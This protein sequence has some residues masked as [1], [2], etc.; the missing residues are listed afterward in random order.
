ME[1]NNN[2]KLISALCY[3]SIFFAG[4]ILPI[5][6]YFI[7]DDYEVKRHATRAL[8]SHLIPLITVPVILIMAI[9][10]ETVGGFG[11]FMILGFVLA[12]LIN[13]VV[14]VWNVVKGVQVL[15]TY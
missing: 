11:I 10:T 1:K 2:H 3:F 14:I 9:L 13:I 15:K 8:F 12:F 6:V 4:F 7:V 5:A